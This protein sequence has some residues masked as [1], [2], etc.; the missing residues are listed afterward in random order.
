MLIHY[1]TGTKILKVVERKVD[2][3][4]R[5]VDKS[6]FFQSTTRQTGSFSSVHSVRYKKEGP[7]KL[8]GPQLIL[9]YFHSKK[10]VDKIINSSFG[11][12]GILYK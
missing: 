7:N 12:I 5:K 8:L 3:C 6:T 1:L 10:S 9:A 11:F 2:N 4:A